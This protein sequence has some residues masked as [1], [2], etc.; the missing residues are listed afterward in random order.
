[1]SITTQIVKP[2]ETGYLQ[3]DASDKHGYV[4]HYK[5]PQKNAKNFATEFKEQDKKL[6]ICSNVLF[7]GSIFA[8][9]LGATYFTKGMESRFKQF[10]IQTASAIT[11]TI[12]TSLGMSKYADT[13]QKNLLNKHNAKEIFYKA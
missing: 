3:V 9:V 4:Q 2:L 11:L 10:M 12:L 6:N 5:V 7:F 13:E 1:M 8:G